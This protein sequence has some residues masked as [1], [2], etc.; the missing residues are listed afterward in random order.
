MWRNVRLRLIQ[1]CQR[2]TVTMQLVKVPV[3]SD[4]KRSRMVTRALKGSTTV[5]EKR[6]SKMENLR[7]C[8]KEK[9]TRNM[10]GSD[11]TSNFNNLQRHWNDSDSWKLVAR[12]IETA[13]SSTAFITFMTVVWKAKIEGI[14]ASR[15]DCVRPTTKGNI[16][17][18]WSWLEAIW[19]YLMK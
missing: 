4:F 3:S 18:K 15:C 13:K 19:E 11:S 12:L 5:E 17:T 7:Y 14:S 1:C 16:Q 6:L 10:I 8:V 9:R 2:I